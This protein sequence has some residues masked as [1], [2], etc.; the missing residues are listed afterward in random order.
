MTPCRGVLRLVAEAAS[1]QDL[2]VHCLLLLQW[3]LDGAWS[4][5]AQLLMT[6]GELGHVPSRVV[7]VRHIEFVPIDGQLQQRV[8]EVHGSRQLD[9]KLQQQLTDCYADLAR[10]QEAAET[11]AATQRSL[12]AAAKQQQMLQQRLDMTK[13]SNRCRKI[14][15]RQLAR[16]TL[17]LTRRLGAY[18]GTVVALEAAR[19]ELREFQDAATAEQAHAAR[20]QSSRLNAQKY[21]PQNPGGFWGVH[22]N[23]FLARCHTAN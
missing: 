20:E 4:H 14:Q 2:A 3:I 21:T 13:Q 7:I 22:F 23:P 9:L 8:A 11:S 12:E 18:Q 10:L 19:R 1:A 5:G 16:K 17:E 15:N 6:V